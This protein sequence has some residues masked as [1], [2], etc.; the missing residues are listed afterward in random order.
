VRGLLRARTIGFNSSGGFDVA[1]LA[2][3]VPPSL[4]GVLRVTARLQ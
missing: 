1:A 4:P 3:T 2:V